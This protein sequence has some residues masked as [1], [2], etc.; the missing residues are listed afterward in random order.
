[1][2]FAFRPKILPCGLRIGLDEAEG[3]PDSERCPSERPLAKDRLLTS[4][5][6]SSSMLLL[7]LAAVVVVVSSD[8]G[9]DWS[10]VL[11]AEQPE[12]PLPVTKLCALPAG[13]GAV[14]VAETVVEAATAIAVAAA[15]TTAAVAVV[16][17]GEFV[18]IVVVVV[19]C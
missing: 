1:M 16:V 11:L 5:C 13:E 3:A 15:A 9:S 7:L 8:W 2:P 6:L 18:S 14:L 17:V 10:R 4:S 19:V 12:L